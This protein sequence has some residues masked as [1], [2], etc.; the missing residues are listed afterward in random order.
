M[1]TMKSMLLKWNKKKLLKF[2]VY[3]NI[4]FLLISSVINV[5]RGLLLVSDVIIIYCF[6]IHNRRM[7]ILYNSESRKVNKYIVGLFFF[8]IIGW[9]L[10]GDS[11]LLFVWGVRNYLRFYLFV[12]C[13]INEFELEDIEAFTFKIFLPLNVIN[14][15]AILYQRYIMGIINSDVIGGIFG[16]VSGCNAALNIFCMLS[17]IYVST[18]RTYLREKL[19]IW[20]Y[21]GYLLIVM[22]TLVLASVF[23]EL[24]IL[25][26][27]LVIVVIGLVM[28]SK[29]IQKKIQWVLTG[30]VAGAVLLLIMSYVFPSSMQF[31]L[32]PERLVWYNAEIGYGDEEAL[33]RLSAIEKINTEVFKDDVL[34]K[35][36]GTGVGNASKI[37]FLGIESHFYQ[38]F[39]RLRYDWFTHAMIYMEQGYLGVGL[40]LLFIIGSGI[41]SFRRLSSKNYY[42][43]WYSF[44]VIVSIIAGFNMIY[45]NALIT[46]NA[47]YL[48][49]FCIAIPFIAGKNQQR[50]KNDIGAEEREEHVSTYGLQALPRKNRMG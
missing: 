45:N 12:S 23:A 22:G 50:Y 39:Q 36:W 16:T 26:F 30:V 9:I 42:R 17:F 32:D 27:E 13:C 18:R 19:S 37:N 40:Y 20:K 5:S 48:C 47:G 1:A 28:T 44:G 38:Q 10:N 24:K 31:L 41:Y 29:G 49:Y 7:T 4:F 6:F 43:E 25:F 21:R 14:F 8:Y 3:Y 15:G 46:E 33:N 2:V 35:W 11:L 34:K